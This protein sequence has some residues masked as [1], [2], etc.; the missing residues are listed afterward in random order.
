[1]SE[2]AGTEADRPGRGKQH[3]QVVRKELFLHFPP[4][5]SL[6]RGCICPTLA[7]TGPLG[8]IAGLGCAIDSL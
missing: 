8:A 2:A 1:M 7:V 5:L 3:R 4:E 6:L